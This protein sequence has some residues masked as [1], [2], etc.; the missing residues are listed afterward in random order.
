[1]KMNSEKPISKLETIK[2]QIAEQE[3]RAG[4]KKGSVKLIAVSKTKPMNQIE[5]VI[6][7][8]QSHFGE[9]KVQEAALK[10]QEFKKKNKTIDLHLLGPLQSNKV[11]KVFG[12]FDYIH[13]LDRNSLAEKISDEAQ[14]RGFCPKLFIQVNTG[15]EEQKAGIEPEKLND[16]VKSIRK[17]LDLNIV[18]LMCI[19]PIN[20]AAETHFKLLKKLA[21]ENGLLELSMGMSSDYVAAIKCGATYVRVGTAIFGL[22]H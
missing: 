21:D 14:K 12:L 7:E 13:S 22:R 19:P 6:E 9:N 1:M 3:I 16:F 10:W 2:N 17:S 5:P 8:G 15:L 20:D 4:K 18:G 11:K